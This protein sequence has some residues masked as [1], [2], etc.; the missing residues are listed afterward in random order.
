[1]GELV[2]FGF[3]SPWVVSRVAAKC[4]PK[5]Y[6]TAQG[7]VKRGLGSSWEGGRGPW[8]HRFNEQER[9]CKWVWRPLLYLTTYHGGREGILSRGLCRGTRPGDLLT[10]RRVSAPPSDST[11]PSTSAPLPRGQSQGRGVSR[12]ARPPRGLTSSGGPSL[13]GSPACLRAA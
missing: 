5:N 1:M 4:L 9:S 6:L 11:R 10:T 3:R 13:S 12:A 2:T 7:E 8:A